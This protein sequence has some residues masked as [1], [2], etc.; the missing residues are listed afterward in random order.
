MSFPLSCRPCRFRGSPTSAS[1]PPGQNAARRGGIDKRCT[2]FERVRNNTTTRNTHRNDALDMNWLPE[3]RVVYVSQKLCLWRTPR[4][5]KATRECPRDM[6][7]GSILMLPGC[8]QRM[9]ARSCDCLLT[10]RVGRR[11][12]NKLD[13][14]NSWSSFTNKEGANELRLTCAHADPTGFNLP[15]LFAEAF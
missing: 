13:K 6:G 3:V 1:V 5:R 12:K 8:F 11:G 2:C 4:R 7:T 15:T 9:R 14:K 10:A